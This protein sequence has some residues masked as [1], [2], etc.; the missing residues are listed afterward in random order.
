V[1]IRRFPR[2]AAAAVVASA[3]LALAALAAGGCSGD[4]PPRPNL[5][6]VSFD[7]LRADRL[8]AYGNDDWG[9][10]TSPHA[11]ALAARGTLLERCV[12]PR[13]QTHPSLGALLTGKYPITTGL[14]ENSLLLTPEHR[15][16]FQILKQAGWITGV[17][18]ANFDKQSKFDE[19]VFRGA[20]AK[21]DGFGGRRDE[22]VGGSAA[23]SRFQRQW[24]DRVE[25]AALEFL[26][27]RKGNVQAGKPFAAWV[28]FYD[29]HKP[30]NPP[31]EYA[32]LYGLDA[33]V[34]AVLRAP[35]PD[36]GQ[37]LED[38]LA[39]ITLTDRP[40]P[41]A[42]LR[43]ILGLYDGGVT[44]TDAR[45][46][47]LLDKLDD[48][49]LTEST[50]VVFTSDHGDDLFDHNRYFFHG[51]SVY[52]STLRIP[53]IVAGAG[54]PMAARRD[55]V[56]QNIDVAPTV[57]DLLGVQPPADMEGA[58]LVGLLRNTTTAPPRPY[59]FI[60]WQDVLYAVTD[61]SRSYVHN[62]SHA[63]L[64]KEPFAPPK[65]QK[66]TRG[67]AIDCYEGYDLATDPS[68]QHNLLAG[69]DPAGLKSG[70]A[71]PP[72][73]AA[74]RKALNAWLADPRHERQMSWPGLSQQGLE[75]MEQLG[76]VGGNPDRPDVLFCAPCD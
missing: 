46:G 14:R 66:A 45:L 68:E 34:P 40:V 61:G 57:L 39:G 49:G 75:R 43:R 11:D 44:A 65:G 10:T 31:A 74:M 5:L 52:Q 4:E 60:E 53:L 35:G 47:R 30:Y 22:Q 71:L 21:A 16:L 6:I 33:D 64:L 18:V 36:S 13:G 17:F 59:A 2:L 55:A 9:T 63:N 37:E 41:E 70:D 56:V 58:S 24:D 19:W 15:T 12:A 7:T 27:G 67:Y 25:Q 69:L 73:F 38:Y 29:V 28:H 62:P 72:E 26:E 1:P 48:L 23:E 42:E 54:L 50:V 8:G 20:D 3:T 76:Y 51:N 32:A